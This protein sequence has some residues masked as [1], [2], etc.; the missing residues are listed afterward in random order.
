M[1]PAT[2]KTIKETFATALDLPATERDR[3]L[4]GSS[5]EI[6]AEVE[7]LLASY[8]EAQ[9]FIGTPIIVEKGLRPDAFEEKVTGKKIDDYCV[10]EKIGEGGMGTVFLAEHTGQGFSQ[11]VA[12]KLIKRGMD[13][14]A[15]L[16]RFLMERQILAGLEHPNIARLYGGGST[17]DGLPYFVME[18]VEGE[19]IRDFCDKRRFDTDERLRLF[20]KVCGAVSYAHQQL[21]VHRDLKPS[22]II[23]TA[24]GEPKLLDFG[25]AK[26]L[27]PDSRAAERT[28]TQFHV[29]TP[30]YASPEQL[31]GNKTTTATDVYSLGVV[32]YEL[33]TGTR[34]FDF[35][36]KSLIE[37][38]DALRTQRPVRPSECQLVTAQAGRGTP[39]ASDAN[40]SDTFSEARV[41]KPQTSARNLKGD[42]DNIIL[43]AIRREP[44][45]RYQS[46][47]EFSED[48][49]RYL[50]G[51]PVKATSDTVGYRATKF[52]KRHRTVFVATVCFMLL[53]LV[54]TT[55]T[56]W[57]YFVARAQRAKAEARLN[58]LRGVAKSLLTETNAAL[59][60]MPESLE[61]RKSVVER[62]IAVLDT[63]AAE[64][65]NDLNFVTELA[66]AYDELGK[67]RFWSFHQSRLAISDYQ[68]ALQLRRRAAVLAPN[69]IQ[70]LNKFA[71]TLPNMA[72]V[73]S[74]QADREGLMRVWQ[75]QRGIDQQRLALDSNNPETLNSVSIH[76]QELADA[77]QLSDRADESATQLKESFA[78]IEHAIALQ[79]TRPFSYQGQ[80]LLVAFAMQKAELLHRWQRSDEA[81]AVYQAA[82]DLAVQTYQA[83][84]S[85]M[86]AFN[87]ASRIHR[88]MA[89]IYAEKGD[90]QKYLEASDFSVNWIKENRER[91]YRYGWG[92]PTAECFYVLREGVGLSKLGQ[93][94]AAIERLDEGMNLYHQALQAHAFHG[95]DVLYA[96]EELETATQ[97]YLDASQDDKA[98]K[99]WEEYAELIQPF[100]DR[101]PDDTTSLN[102]LAYALDRKGDVLAR[103]QKEPD[104]FNQTEPL[105][106]R[107]ALASY[108][109]SDLRRQR[110]LQLDATNQ[111]QVDAQKVLASKISRLGSL[112][113]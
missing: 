27:L 71:E 2:W 111:S 7:K 90:W 65:N 77:L 99:L 41:R 92:S 103:Y 108:Q 19:S 70:V 55:I 72:E 9:A 30:E 59:K 17:N 80:V 98:V 1:N 101:N 38:S 63:L 84:N 112:I 76:R 39:T 64:E 48:I 18:H 54:S 44:E 66:D 29:M 13:T 75:E 73:Y 79:Q 69:N 51:L 12:L 45:R 85:K 100:V 67:M 83:D 94:Q 11:R 16:G 61:I 89:D 110:M 40:G 62:S 25:I 109:E 46:V 8:Q 56:G 20:T 74:A 86:F 91:L 43:Q 33:L 52:I 88:Y 32:L 47:V 6:R 3:L 22:N 58:Q 113:N 4:A 15:V 102:L 53:L 14:N 68:K 26:L 104:T 34:P 23:V 49:E 36:G 82:A 50:S 60:K 35:K 42:L 78:L 97:G 21:I 93:K 106:L 81:L 28:A 24:S 87:H 96:P 107:A 10:L 37:I 105:R 95:E 31:S 5:D 57:Q